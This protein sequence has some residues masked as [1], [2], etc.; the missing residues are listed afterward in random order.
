MEAK[1]KKTIFGMMIF[2]CLV[3]LTTIIVYNNMSSTRLKRQLDLG[4]KYLADL[5]Y[6]QAVAAFTKAVEIMPDSPEAKELL[7]TTYLAWADDLLAKGEIDRALSVLE[8]GYAMISDDRFKNKLDELKKTKEE[9]VTKEPEQEETGITPE[10]SRAVYD[11]LE[12]M[13]DYEVYGRPFRD[14]DY[15][16][17]VDYVHENAIENMLTG[18]AN[19]DH[20]GWLIENGVTGEI[21]LNYDLVTLFDG[22]NN[23]YYQFQRDGFELGNIVCYGPNAN[24][25]VIWMTIEEFFARFDLDLETV[26]QNG[27][28]S[29]D[30]I[31]YS[32]GVDSG[33]SWFVTEYILT[34]GSYMVGVWDQNETYEGIRFTVRENNIETIM[35]EKT[36]Q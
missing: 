29:A 24:Y 18:V 5:D 14:W 19:P 27:R 23:C 16:S 13:R 35:M 31:T 25:P 11:A 17:M 33:R 22:N 20:E 3:F 26:C 12:A 34:P 7:I 6:E 4:N 10:Q 15:E 21:M 9:E 32:Y 30:Q 28:E 8:E 2:L 1:Y 36:R